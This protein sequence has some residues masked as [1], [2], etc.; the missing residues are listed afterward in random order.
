MKATASRPSTPRFSLTL[1]SS[2]LCGYLAVK[3]VLCLG[4]GLGDR[5][6]SVG[7]CISCLLLCWRLDLRC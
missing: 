5:L 6:A 4:L 1:W 3:A 2:V 7:T